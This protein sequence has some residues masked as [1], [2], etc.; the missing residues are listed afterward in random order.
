M[1]AVYV[2]RPHVSP[3]VRAFVDWIVERFERDREGV[4]VAGAMA[5][6]LV[7]EVVEMNDREGSQVAVA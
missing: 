5:R 7:P 3:G 4:A 1:S 6:Q 2:K